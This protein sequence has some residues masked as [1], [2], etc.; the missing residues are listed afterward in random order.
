VREVV[1]RC[2]G[3]FG[4]VG[5][6]GGKFS[7]YMEYGILLEVCMLRCEPERDLGVESFEVCVHFANIKFRNKVTQ[8]WRTLRCGAPTLTYVSTSEAT[9]S[10]ASKTRM[11][12]R[13]FW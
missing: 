4:E 7:I 1:D 10:K 5:A 11:A 6:E 9:T 2:C 12:A 8:K 13:L 3:D